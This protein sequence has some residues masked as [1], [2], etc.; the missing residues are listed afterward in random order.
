M[1][2][3]SAAGVAGVGTLGFT[4][5]TEFTGWDTVGTGGTVSWRT[6]GVAP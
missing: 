5:S 6:G 2:A 4:A 1:G 3:R